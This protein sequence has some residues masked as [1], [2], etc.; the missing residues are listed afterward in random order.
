MSARPPLTRD[1]PVSLSQVLR[2]VRNHPDSLGTSYR[3][4][5]ILFYILL[6]NIVSM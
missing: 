6:L 2:F 4:N 5:Y 3:W 1:D